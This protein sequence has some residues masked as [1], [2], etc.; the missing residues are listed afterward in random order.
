MTSPAHAEPE[1]VFVEHGGEV[2]V[3]LSAEDEA[4]IFAAGLDA[5]A[6]LVA[7]SAHGEPMEVQIELQGHERALLLV[8]WLNELLFRAELEQ[9]VPKHIGAIEL[10]EERLQ[11]TVVGYRGTT[12]LLVK[13]VALNRLVFERKG[14]VWHGRVVFDV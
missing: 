12:R 14:G 2:E 5:F 8:D 11:A 6:E 13:G 1:H 3:E 9:F 7:G 10:G 4:G